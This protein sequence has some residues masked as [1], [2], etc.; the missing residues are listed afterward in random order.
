MPWVLI[1]LIIAAILFV[2]AAFNVASPRVGLV[3]AGL[4]FV[5]LSFILGAG[6]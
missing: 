6:L 3:P 5:V 4:F 1:C 2:L